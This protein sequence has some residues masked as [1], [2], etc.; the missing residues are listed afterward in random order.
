MLKTAYQITTNA[1]VSGQHPCTAWLKLVYPNAINLLSVFIIVFRSQTWLI[2]QLPKPPF[3]ESYIRNAKNGYRKMYQ[4][5]SKTW[6]KSRGHEANTSIVFATCLVL[7]R[8]NKCVTE[9]EWIS[10]IYLEFRFT[11]IF[12]FVVVIGQNGQNVCLIFF[13]FRCVS[14]VQLE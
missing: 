5:H 3:P 4:A 7:D 1:S 12:K 13:N 14:A 6:P 10:T 8:L 2:R 11:S 9:E